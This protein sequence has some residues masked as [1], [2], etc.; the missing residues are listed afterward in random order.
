MSTKDVQ[1]IYIMQVASQLTGMHPQTLRKYEREGLLT[2]S[3]SKKARLYTEDNIT[4]LREIKHLVNVMGLN[5]AGVRLAL[6]IRDRILGMKEV[7]ASANHEA[8]S[9]QRLENL[10]DDIL[11]ILRNAPLQGKVASQD[12]IFNKK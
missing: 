7:L 12:N 1:G 3:R 9:R 6:G 11:E 8:E 5:M 2:P 10:L 4:R